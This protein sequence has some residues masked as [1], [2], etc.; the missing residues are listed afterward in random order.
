MRYIYNIK[1][2]KCV[3]MRFHCAIARLGGNT[4]TILSALPICGESRTQHRTSHRASSKTAKLQFVLNN[5]TQLPELHL[6][7][8]SLA[9]RIKNSYSADLSAKLSSSR[10]T[11]SGSASGSKLQKKREVCSIFISARTN[12]AFERAFPFSTCGASGWRS[13]RTSLSYCSVTTQFRIEIS[14]L[15]LDF[16]QT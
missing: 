9:N 13:R 3:R 15:F 2:W 11:P 14:K 4:G 8:H 12:M 16:F 6:T 10:M 7:P 1:F 5:T